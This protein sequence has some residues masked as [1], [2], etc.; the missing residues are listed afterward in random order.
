MVQL[1]VELWV[2][3]LELLYPPTMTPIT[4]VRTEKHTM[5]MTTTIII[6]TTTIDTI[7]TGMNITLH[8]FARQAKQR[9]EIAEPSNTLIQHNNFKDGSFGAVS[10]APNVGALH[11]NGS[12]EH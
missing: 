12:S 1:L 5:M 9:K 8:I 4:T 7:I 10:F 3:R 2:E 11:L 6:V